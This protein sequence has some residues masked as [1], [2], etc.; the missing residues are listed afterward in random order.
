[1][2]GWECGR[3]ESSN[4]VCVCV[5]WTLQ[6]MHTRA[7]KAQD[8]CSLLRDVSDWSRECWRSCFAIRS[9]PLPGELHHFTGIKQCDLYAE[10]TFTTLTKLRSYKLQ[11]ISLC[12]AALGTRREVIKKSN[13]TFQPRCFACLLNAA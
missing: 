9:A 3:S 10:K 5:F 7:S 2:R 1:M 13:F 8:K 12:V 4:C 6:W 11:T